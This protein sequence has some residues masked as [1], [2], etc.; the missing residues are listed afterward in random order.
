M[1]MRLT[2]TVLSTLRARKLSTIKMPGDP[3]LETADELLAL[4]NDPERLKTYKYRQP[5]ISSC[6]INNEKFHL[7]LP[8]QQIKDIVDTCKIGL[9]DK[10]AAE[11]RALLSWEH[12]G[13][14]SI[15]G[16]P[17]A[18]MPDALLLLPQF[19]PSKGVI[20]ALLDCGYY[21]S[22]TGLSPQDLWFFLVFDSGLLKDHKLTLH[23]TT[24]DN[25]AARRLLDTRDM[26]KSEEWAFNDY[27][28]TKIE[29]A[30][31][32]WMDYKKDKG[33]N[34]KLLQMLKEKYPN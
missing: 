10:V 7:D 12:V 22:S 15:P 26:C 30:R 19:P 3:K 13:S 25:P 11:E 23:I 28:N 4:F 18:M 32:S 1:G 34:S 20:Q 14:T 17:G 27:K 29:A 9:F 2:L 8:Y 21:Y 33:N 6:G 24:R 16:M 5:I 31:G